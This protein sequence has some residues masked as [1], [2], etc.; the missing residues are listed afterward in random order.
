MPS[1]K[2]K[3]V[4]WSV[5]D[6]FYIPLSDKDVVL[7][8]IVGREADLLNSV[9]VALFD[10]KCKPEEVAAALPFISASRAFSV[11]FT[12]RDLLDMGEWPLHGTEP[13]SIPKAQLPYEHLRQDRFIGAKVIGSGIVNEFVNAFYGL[14]S[15]DDWKDPNYLDGLLLSPAKKPQA[16]LMY[17]RKQA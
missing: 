5:G 11:L 7:G 14:T 6:V 9:T 10:V 8:Q 2:T 15:W 13:V 1:K 4:E 3:K 17:K 12:T 16:R